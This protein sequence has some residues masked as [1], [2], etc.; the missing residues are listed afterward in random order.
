MSEANRAFT[1]LVDMAAVCRSHARALPSREEKQ[2]FWTGVGIR[3]HQN[4]YVCPLED[5]AEILKVPPYTK[6]PGVGSWVNG[7]ANV[8]GK[9]LPLLDMNLFFFGDTTN[10]AQSRRRVLVLDE[11]EMYTGLIVDHVL[12]MQHFPADGFHQYVS[13]VPEAIKPFVEGCYQRD[14]EIWCVFRPKRLLKDSRFMK[15]AG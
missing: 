1:T 11:G 14:D 6:L 5:V 13:N 12:G 9:L 4:L 15:L 10:Q 7:V 3:L 2:L 8:R